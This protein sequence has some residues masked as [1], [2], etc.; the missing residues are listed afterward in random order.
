MKRLVV[1]IDC[2]AVSIT[3]L[4][5]VGLVGLMI[6]GLFLE[7]KELVHDLY[8]ARSDWWIAGILVFFLV[9]AAFRWRAGLKALDELNT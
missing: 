1:I 2:A 8:A 3:M 9:W 5:L 7:L 4:F 6:R